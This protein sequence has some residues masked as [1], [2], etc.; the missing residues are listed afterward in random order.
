MTELRKRYFNTLGLDLGGTSARPRLE[1]A[2]ARA[3]QQRSFEIEH[4]W[5]RAT[6]FWGFQIAIFAAFGLLWR[7][8]S[9][10][11]WNP[12]TVAL[13]ALGFLTAV[14]N[15]ISARG[16]KFWQ[17]NWEHHIDMLEDAIEGR[18]Y[19]TV[20]LRDGGVSFSVSGVNRALSACFIVFWLLVA[21]YVAWKFLG[22][23]LLSRP[24]CDIFRGAYLLFVVLMVVVGLLGLLC[25][26]T[27]FPATIPKADG[28]RG[29]STWLP[30]CWWC[31]SRRVNHLEFVRRDAPD[32]GQ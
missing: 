19:K 5:K 23:P 15:H 31:L 12:V 17:E 27:S 1:A 7:A 13:A 2:L 18:L 8:S 28:S 25:Q 22:S 10:G 24:A 21:I 16:S 11:D 29:D 6:Y 14:A 9:T 30:P 32:E 3:Y 20:W 26:R 4:Y